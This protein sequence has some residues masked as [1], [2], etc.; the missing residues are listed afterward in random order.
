M[1][2][3]QKDFQDMQRRVY[4]YTK[5][6]TILISGTRPGLIAAMDKLK[7]DSIDKI[8]IMEAKQTQILLGFAQ[9][10]AQKRSVLDEALF[11]VTSGTA[12]WAASIN[13]STLAGQMDYTHTDIV[14]ITDESIVNVVNGILTLVT[15][16]ILVPALNGFGV[17]GAA[18]TALENARDAYA[19]VES[20]PIEMIELRASYTE[21]IDPLVEVGRRILEDIAD[22]AADTLK[23]TQN[24]WWKGY[25]KE[26][27]IIT[28]GVHHNVIEGHML[29]SVVV[30]GQQQ[31]LYGGTVVATHENGK[32]YTV[33]TN[34]T[35]Y[36]KVSPAMPGVF[37]SIK[38]IAPNHQELTQNAFRLKK[39]TTV[40]KDV[41]LTAN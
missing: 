10:K 28:T 13:N 14:N 23:G 6:D 32:V 19:L 16:H 33:K 27:T 37:S 40:V 34:E 38:F 5:L 30:G 15:P 21:A 36:Y 7:T 31:P 22:K 18:K 39:G 29:S 25:K 4:K 35:G 11:L 24:E 9:N 12:G 3:V 8:D 17:D 20:E 41:T 1:N 26:R 2:Q